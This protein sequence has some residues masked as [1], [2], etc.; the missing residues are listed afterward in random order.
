[1][2]LFFGD[3]INKLQWATM[4]LQVSGLFLVSTAINADEGSNGSVAKYAAPLLATSMCVTA[5]TSVLFSRALKNFEVPI[6]VFTFFMYLSSLLFNLTLYLLRLTSTMQTQ[7]FAGYKHNL[8]AVGVVVT[9]C[10]AGV[11]FSTLSKYGDAIIARYASSV[12]P[13]TRH[14]RRL[15]FKFSVEDKPP[16]PPPPPK[17]RVRWSERNRRVL[18]LRWRPRCCVFWRCRSSACT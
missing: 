7:F 8:W 5:S 1:M 6:P 15:F 18:S 16:P 11:S 10:L 4:L 14:K 3:N 17:L 9:N 12:P 2:W 13:H